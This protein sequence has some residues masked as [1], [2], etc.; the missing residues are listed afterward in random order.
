[1]GDNNI[2]YNIL[3]YI[4]IWYKRSIDL[5]EET[6]YIYIYIYIYIYTSKLLH[7]F[8][9]SNTYYYSNKYYYSKGVSH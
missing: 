3:L 5:Y 2:K 8:N 6:L 1:M 7:I 9:Y 4:H